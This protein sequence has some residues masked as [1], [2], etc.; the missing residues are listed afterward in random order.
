MKTIHND[1]LAVQSTNIS[2]AIQLAF[3]H[4]TTTPIYTYSFDPTIGTNTVELVN[5]H[6]E[7]WDDYATIVIQNTALG[8]PDMRG[9]YV[10]I[11]YG[12]NT[13]SGLRY[14][15]APRLWVVEQSFL[16]GPKQLKSILNLS[17]IMRIMNQLEIHIGT[18]PLWQDGAGTLTGK[19]IYG[20]FEYLIET[21]LTAQTGYTFTLDA[22]GTQDDGIIN[23]IVPSTDWEFILNTSAPEVYDTYGSLIKKLIENTNCFLRPEPN[24]AFKIVWPQSSDAVDETYYSSVASGHVFYENIDIQ[25]AVIPNHI[26]VVANEAGDWNV[27]GDAYNADDYSA[28]P[29]YSGPFMPV[30]KSEAMGDV[31]NETDADNFAAAKLAKVK[32]ESMS[33]RTVVPHDARV[34]LYDK[35]E[36][37]DARGV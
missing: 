32:A 3:T 12:A 6:E 13:A 17:G 8:V 1:L 14:S 28:P 34:E 15:A 25:K 23:D 26:A 4:R 30:D 11:G 7:P 18:S 22:L 33:G 27:I 19:T 37:S 24:L 35:I 36:T 31:T 16:S 9:Y 5:H 20:V 2:P 29:T 10:D 21:A